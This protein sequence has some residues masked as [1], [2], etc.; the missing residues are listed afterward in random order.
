VGDHLLFAHPIGIDLYV[1]LL[2]A[3]RGGCIAVFPDPS[4]GRSFLGQCCERLPIRGFFGS[5]KA[6]FLRVLVPGIRRIQKH[7]WPSLAKF[8]GGSS[9][10]TIPDGARISAD[11]P[12]LITFTSGSTGRP[13]GIVRSHRFLLDQHR[14]LA[15]AMDHREPETDLCTLPVFVLANLASG[16]TTVLANTDLARPG[17]CD[18]TAVGAQIRF[19]KTSR[20]AASPALME[21]LLDG[22]PSCLGEMRRI[23]TGGAPVLPSLLGRLTQAAPTADVMAVY[24]SSEAEPIAELP[25]S[26][27]GPEELAITQRGGGLLAGVPVME[28]GL[29][30]LPDRWGAESE[31][32]PLGVDH[33]GEIVVTGDHVLK[34]YLDS[35]DDS[36]TKFTGP[37]GEI[38]HRTGDAGRIDQYGRLWLLGRC[39]ARIGDLYPFAVEAALDVHSSGIGRTALI[40]VE[41]ESGRSRR[42]LVFEGSLSEEAEN[43]LK[44]D[45]DWASIDEWRAVPAIPVDRRHN[46]KVDYPALQRLV[47]GS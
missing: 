21:R 9:G 12:A 35:E 3:L 34:G 43:Q 41:S 13:K 4:A 18:A 10:L 15:R 36:E 17:D 8:G 22:D 25:A 23:D 28:I 14:A 38:W 33:V 39:T 16:M 11:H 40:E 30:I 19:E 47:S 20:V 37:D 31:F 6:H 7:F 27:Y 45:L 44:T 2:G 5:P 26:E 46:A 32:A 24:G 29:K 1:V 42:L